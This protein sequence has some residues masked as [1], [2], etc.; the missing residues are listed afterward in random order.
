MRIWIL[1][2]FYPPE[3]GAA[4]VRLSRLARLLAADGHIVTV[5]TGMPNYPE[6][7]IAP[8]YRGR[9]FC[10]ETRDGVDIQRVWVYASPSK[11]ARARLLNQFSFMLMAA[12]RGTF[13]RRPDVIL[14]ESHPLSVCLSGGWLRRVKRAPVVLNVSDLWP[15]SAVATGALRADSLLVRGAIPVERWAYHDAAHVVGMTDG[16]MDGIRQILPDPQRTRTTLIKNAVDLVRF[17]PGQT[18]L[19]AEV[20]ARYRLEDGFVVVHVGNMSLTYDF[21]IMLEA[22]ASLPEITFLFVGGG[23]QTERIESQVSDQ[24]L[25]NVRFTGVL[26]HDDMP[27]IWAVA[28]GCLIALGDHSVAG[29]TL[30]AKMYEALATGTPIV[31]AIRGEGAALLEQAGAGMVVPIGDPAPMVAALRALKDS[32]EQRAA[33]SAAGREYAETALSP[34]RVKRAYVEIFERVIQR[35]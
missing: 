18:E 20:R 15:E 2:Q 27:G 23:S 14:V 33:M 1:T 11:G 10:R 3:F 16:V 30:P 22:A 34:E 25:N 32:P 26:P 31:A 5:L 7:V 35:G 6:G 28:D 21:D 19:R 24:K 13:L 12:L 9:V 29:G 8:E 17:R 4:A